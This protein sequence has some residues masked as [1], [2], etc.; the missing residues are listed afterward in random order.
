MFSPDIASKGHYLSLFSAG[1]GQP[2]LEGPTWVQIFE[3]TFYSANNK[4]VGEIFYSS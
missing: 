1:L 3:V 4:S 2:S